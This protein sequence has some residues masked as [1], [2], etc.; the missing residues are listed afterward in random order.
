MVPDL[1]PPSWD[2]AF[3]LLVGWLSLLPGLPC[4]G[5]HFLFW[6]GCNHHCGEIGLGSSIREPLRSLLLVFSSWA[7]QLRFLQ[8]SVW[9]VKWQLPAPGAGENPWG[10]GEQRWLHMYTSSLFP[11]RSPQ[12]GLC[13]GSHSQK[14]VLLSRHTPNGRGA[15]GQLLRGQRDLA[16]WFFNKLSMHLPFPVFLLH[17]ISWRIWAC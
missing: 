3:T 1:Q 6:W 15:V 17:L 11:R 10:E 16:F 12:L 8:S 9:R 13:W 4:P 2:C 14:P 5:P 7:G